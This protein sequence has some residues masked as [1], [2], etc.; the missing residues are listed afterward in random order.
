MEALQIEIRRAVIVEATACKNV[1]TASKSVLE[2]SREEKVKL[3]VSSDVNMEAFGGK[4]ELKLVDMAYRQSVLRFE[5][6]EV[7]AFTRSGIG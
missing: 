7:Y 3:S 2:S 5:A 6:Q 4:K 1:E